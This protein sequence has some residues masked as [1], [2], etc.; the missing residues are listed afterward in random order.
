LSKSAVLAGTFGYAS[1]TGYLAN[2]YKAVTTVFVDPAQKAGA[3]GVLTGTSLSL[4]EK[5]PDERNIFT[6]DL[7]YIQHI[8]PLDAALHANYRFYHDDW[9]IDSHTFE[10]DWAQPLFDGW[11]VTPL[12]RYYSQSAADFYQPYLVSFQPYPGKVTI[13]KGQVSISQLNAARLPANYSSDQ[14]LSAFG[15]ISTG[16][17]I[18]KRFSK[19]VSL[20]LGAEYYTHAGSLR[21][22]G[23]G[24]G[25][26]ADFQYYMFNAAVKL[27]LSAP[28]LPG[29][30]GGHAGHEGHE[31]HGG[32]DHAAAPAGVM[33]DHMLPKAGGWM[34]GYRYMYMP[35][36]GE[37][38]RGLDGVSDPVVVAKG[39]YGRPCYVT[40]TSM[41]MH[42]HMLDVM[43]AP[44][45]W[46]TLMLMPQYMDMNMSMR[47]LDGAPS[48]IAAPPVTA[49][50]VMH[51]YHTHQ[52][53][54]IGDTGLYAMFKAFERDGH[55]LH[56][57]LGIS[58][59][60]GDVGIQLRD[61]HGLNIGFIHY[62]MQLGSGT[63]D[64]KPSLTYTGQD[65]RWS[66]GAQL[67]AVKRL[68]QR[69]TSGF[70][71][72]DQMQSTFWG[73]YKL[74]SWLS[75]SVRGLYT[76]Q[77]GLSGVYNDTYAPVGPMDY[78]NNYGGHFWDLGFGLSAQVPTGTLQGSRFGVEWLQP[79]YDNP[80][81]YQLPRQGSLAVN[82]GYAF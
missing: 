59:P 54:G 71:F 65:G 67:S 12:L 44:T 50:A 64:F 51:A 75:A 41:N 16:L 79:V 66:W 33:F 3:N 49:A 7:S 5:R 38:R 31:G 14:R 52:T 45:D 76:A 47:P 28:A 43:Y 26:Y 36:N 78:G 9:G 42:M 39:C 11:T 56:A 57:T 35:E 69:N 63:W 20:E 72:G 55:H 32:H 2:P 53:G 1:N 81:G 25:A 17:S 68:E 34:F 22:G 8:N 30:G 73:G 21:L 46:L 74:Y 4:L 24:E 40:P 80:N 37:M 82:W 10:A 15:A 23:G 48:I 13:N 70:A 27:D 58:A 60:T 61:T 19:G 29:G 18:S 77:G 6:G 62:G